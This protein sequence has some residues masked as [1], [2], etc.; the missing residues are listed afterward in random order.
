[1]ESKKAG[2]TSIDEYIAT[3]P[4]D[5]QKIL[6]ELRKTIKAAA[7][8]AGRKSVINY[9]PLP[10]MAILSILQLSKT[11][12]GFIPPQAEFRN[13]KMNYPYTKAQK[14]P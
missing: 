12:L 4:E 2:F 10:C 7:P 8:K 6:T 14:A 3:F 11:T 5:T 1:M 9:P 13:S